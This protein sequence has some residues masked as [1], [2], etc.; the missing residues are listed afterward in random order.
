M[1]EGLLNVVNDD[2]S[3]YV[4]CVDFSLRKLARL[5]RRLQAQDEFVA[6]N[7]FEFSLTN[8]KA[9]G[10][11]AACQ[12]LGVTPLCTNVLD[13]GLAT[14]RYTSTNPTG[15]EASKGEGDTGPFATRRLEK[16][17]ALFQVQE[18]LRDKVSRGIGD[19]LLKYESGRAPKINRDITT[20]QIAINYVVAK[21]AVPLVPVN[22]LKMANEL[23][24]CLGWD[25]SEEQV[26]ELDKA[27]KDCGV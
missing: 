17:D 8:R 10:M 20:T 21:G 24:G 23:L 1:A 14:G 3:R 11:I 19:R 18:G 22:N 25:L 6:S 9:L 13:G 4:G 27:C 16:L 12:K 26:E 2:H 7:Q 5:Q 15:G